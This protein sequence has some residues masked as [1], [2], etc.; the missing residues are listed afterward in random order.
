MLVRN[1]HDDVAKLA[2]W[3]SISLSFELF[4]DIFKVF[5][6]FRISERLQVLTEYDSHC[7]EVEDVA[8]ASQAAFAAIKVKLLSQLVDITIVVCSIV[9][10]KVSDP[11]LK[12]LFSNDLGN[13]LR[14]VLARVTLVDFRQREYEFPLL[15]SVIQP[16]NKDTIQP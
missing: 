3:F 7:H 13:A 14:N 2:Q 15:A 11:V 4:S 10:H 16:V 12:L 6:P 9:N 8:N 5:K 1:P